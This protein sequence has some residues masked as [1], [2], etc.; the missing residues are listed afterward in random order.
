MSTNNTTTGDK[1]QLE[2]IIGSNNVDQFRKP[3][4]LPHYWELRKDFLLLHSQKFSFDRLICL[5][6]VFVNVECLGVRYHDDVMKL[7]KEL[8]SQ[9]KSLE[10]YKYNLEIDDFEPKRKQA[11]SRL[12]YK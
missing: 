4:E 8:G 5:S 3:Y 2:R 7:V 6:N 12:Q 1:A 9:V 10:T 11:P